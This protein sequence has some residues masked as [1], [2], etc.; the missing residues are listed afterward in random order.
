RHQL[1]A[2]L[3]DL[4]G[5]NRLTRSYAHLP[6]STADEVATGH[7]VGWFQE[8]LAHHEPGS[9]YWV[10]D[11]DHR[12]RV[13]E[14]IVPALLIGGWHDLFLASQLEDYAALRAAG[15]DPHLTL[16][17]WTHT[18]P[19][20]F[21]AAIGESLA[22]FRAHVTGDRSG[23]RTDPVRL[24]VQ[25]AGEWRDY[26]AWPPPAVP[27]PLRLH[28]DGTL[29]TDAPA[30]S[31]PSVYSYDPADPTP[32]IGGPLLGQG[33]GPRNQKDVEARSDVLVFTSTALTED[34]EVIG[35]VSARIHLRS[36]EEHTDLLLRLCDVDA[37][38]RSVNV[39]DGLQR[40]VPGRFP[41]AADGS[42][43]VEIAMWP[44]AHRFR[45]GHRLRV[46]VASGS[47][48]RF[49]RNP[50]TGDPLGT[51]TRLVVQHQEIL[52]D[53]DHPSALILPVAG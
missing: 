38:G 41:V 52:H 9:A 2:L 30:A 40:L 51:A 34:L 1:V 44:T 31:E 45:A 8:W 25:G 14:V 27:T 53:P 18:A 48:P 46:Q 33:A 20:L 28:A 43:E 3:E 13:P 19:R 12:A 36:S 47:H 29:S 4:V 39:C 23:L 5:T 15:R 26:A 10:P 37:K 22:W 35:E 49:A 7:T 21:G 11:R 24:Y 42:R 6:L 32:G 50:G 16:G 17:P